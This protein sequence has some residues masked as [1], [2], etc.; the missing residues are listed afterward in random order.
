[1]RTSCSICS[2]ELILAL[3]SCVQMLSSM[4]QRTCRPIAI[5]IMLSGRTLSID[6]SSVST[7]PS[8]VARAKFARL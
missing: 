8:G 3:R 5:A 1:M 2:T 7:A 6:V 4:P